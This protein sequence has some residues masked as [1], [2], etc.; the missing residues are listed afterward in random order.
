VLVK[1]MTRWAIALVAIASALSGVSLL[2]ATGAATAASDSGC[3]AESPVQGSHANQCDFSGV[4]RLSPS[5]AMLASVTAPPAPTQLAASDV[6]ATSLTLSWS[7]GGPTSGIAGY[8]VFANATNIGQSTTPS[9]TVTN[10]TCATTYSFTVDAY[11]ASGN[12]SAPSSAISVTTP[13]CLQVGPGRQFANLSQALAAATDGVEIIVHAGSYPQTVI[14]RSFAVPVLITN[15]PGDSPTF[16]GLV[17]ES[18]QNVDVSGISSTAEIK[19]EKGSSDIVL[20]HL[21]V[22]FTQQQPVSDGDAVLLTG[23]VA[24]ITLSDSTIVG[25]L[26][27]FVTNPSGGSIPTDITVSRDDIS[28]ASRDLMHIDSVNGLTVEDSDIHDFSTW[29]TAGTQFTA[30]A[31]DGSTT[32]SNVS[33]LT[34]LAAGMYVVGPGL[35]GTNANNAA[36]I[37]ALDAASHTITLSAPATST[38]TGTFTIVPIHHDGFQAIHASNVTIARNRIHFSSW[39]VSG[40]ARSFPFQAI[41][42]SSK[43][44]PSDNSNVQIFSNLIYHWPGTGICLSGSDGAQIANNTVWR[45]GPT[46]AGTGPALSL[47]GH[48]ASDNENVSVWNDIL[49]PGSV[50]ILNGS[51]APV[52]ASNNLA[53]GRVQPAG[54]LGSDLITAT[55]QFVDE[56]NFLLQSTSPAIGQGSDRAGT[57]PYDFAGVPWGSSVNIGARATPSASANGGSAGRPPAGVFGFAGP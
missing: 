35:P 54:M 32:L 11:D 41:I 52:Y 29:D 57:P 13:G 31:Q 37:S 46:A 19:V 14:S 12:H 1:R 20:D 9:F 10:L 27:G 4:P 44:S 33:S 17:F 3:A 56:N 49:G 21:Y 48:G 36:Y 38:A 39:P 40:V 8:D 30:A 24:H 55:P 43:T 15:S 18:A 16:H 26:Y 28:Q 47:N 45:V 50:H 6:S 2:A 25:G 42:L 53:T 23:G 51:S 7:P 22:H 34:G 5:D